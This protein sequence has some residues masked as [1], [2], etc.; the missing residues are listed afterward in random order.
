MLLLNSKHLSH[1]KQLRSGLCF[2][3]FYVRE[4]SAI[5]VEEKY[6]LNWIIYMELFYL[7]MVQKKEIITLLVC[8]WNWLIK[9]SYIMNHLYWTMRLDYYVR[10]CSSHLGQRK[11]FLQMYMIAI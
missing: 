8:E 6:N 3:I 5:Q 10:L 11:D 7:S 4:R 9:N 1:G 2:L